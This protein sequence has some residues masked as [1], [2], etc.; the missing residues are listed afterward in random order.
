MAT[1]TLNDIQTAISILFPTAHS[2]NDYT[3]TTDTSGNTTIHTW[4]NSL[5]AQPTDVQIT[6]AVAAN[7]L[8]AAKLAQ[9][10]ALSVPF[11]AAYSGNVTYMSAT[12]P[13]DDNT[14][15]LLDFAQ[16]IGIADGNSLPDSFAVLDINGSPVTMTYAQLNGLIS[17]I[18]HQSLAAFAKFAGLKAQIAAATTIADVQ[19]VVWS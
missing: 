17:A 9:V 8:A 12:F 5:G 1:P 19:A 10:Q 14:K 7:Q 18:G 15:L 16:A 3:L 11:N 6:T 2:G 13:A 4:N